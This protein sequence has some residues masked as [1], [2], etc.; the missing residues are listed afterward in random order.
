MRHFFPLTLTLAAILG[1]AVRSDAAD[2]P[3][4]ELSDPG[5]PLYEVRPLDRRVHIVTLEGKWNKP[6]NPGK[7]YYI[8]LLFPNGRSYN[9]R[10]LDDTLFR[11][12]EVRAVVQDYQLKRNG[13]AQ[14]GKLAVV[15]SEEKPVTS[16]SGAEV[17]SNV[18]E[19]SWPMDRPV[20]QQPPRTRFAPPP[21]VDVFPPPPAELPPKLIPPPP[22]EPVPPKPAKG[23]AEPAPPPKPSDR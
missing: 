18:L 15:V 14:G 7:S 9:H 16:A 3:R 23:P 17:V 1:F 12:G 2:P 20:V 6:P 13:L 21:K 19:L 5:L 10:V 8:N 22:A 4:L 11:L